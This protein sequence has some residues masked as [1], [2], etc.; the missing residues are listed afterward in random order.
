MVAVGHTHTDTH[1]LRGKQIQLQ[2]AVLWWS[3]VFYQKYS[4]QISV[5]AAPKNKML[6]RLKF[7]ARKC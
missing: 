7:T 6:N 4:Q 3:K 5:T 1:T 2:F